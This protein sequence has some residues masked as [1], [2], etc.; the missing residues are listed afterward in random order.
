[1]IREIVFIDSTEK[2]VLR[3]SKFEFIYEQSFKRI[4][5]QL[6]VTFDFYQ[7]IST[8]EAEEYD[9]LNM[10][11]CLGKLYRR[12]W[13]SF[14]FNPIEE[15]INFQFDLVEDDKIKVHVRLFNE[16]FTG[17]LEFEFFMSCIDIPEVINEIDI[18]LQQKMR[19]NP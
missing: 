12:E 7:A 4:V 17:R 5:F 16:L 9:F 10:K 14:I 11:K 2:P 6:K 8:F 18:V 19:K 13:T 15:K 3:F 1:M